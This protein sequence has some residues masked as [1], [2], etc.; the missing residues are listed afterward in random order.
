MR[1]VDADNWVEEFA[2]PALEASRFS[3]FQLLHSI[4]HHTVCHTHCMFQCLVTSATWT[5]NDRNRTKKTLDY[6]AVSRR[7]ASLTPPIETDHGC[8]AAFYQVKW[9][10]MKKSAEQKVP[11][12]D[13]DSMAFQPALGENFNTAIQSARTALFPDVPRSLIG[14]S[15]SL[16][17]VAPGVDLGTRENLP[18]G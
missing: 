13:Y 4:P 18:S 10:M 6:V 14:G 3:I 12:K 2:V 16:I 7:F 11:K 15:P 5:S 9:K 17:G 1:D 8:V